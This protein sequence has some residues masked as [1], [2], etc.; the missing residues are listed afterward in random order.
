MPP[1][2]DSSRSATPMTRRRWLESSLAAGAALLPGALPDW[3][4]AAAG[5]G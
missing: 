4:A 5:S 2:P 3:A 1:L